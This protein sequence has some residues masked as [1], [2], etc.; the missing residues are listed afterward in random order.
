MGHSYYEGWSNCVHVM[1]PLTA[2]LCLSLTSQPLPLSPLKY[3]SWS[4]S[5]LGWVANLDLGEMKNAE[6]TTQKHQG[7]K[8]IL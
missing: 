7:M 3:P 6:T 8:A 5:L 2:P 4:L 1:P